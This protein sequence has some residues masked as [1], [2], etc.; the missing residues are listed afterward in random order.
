MHFDTHLHFDYETKSR[1]NLKVHGLARYAAHPSTQIQMVSYAFNDDPVKQWTEDDIDDFP[2]ELIEAIRDP[3]VLKHAHNAAFERA[4][5]AGVLGIETDPRSWRCTMAWA[6][7]LGL[8]GALER[9]GPVLRLPPEMLKFASGKK[10]MR[11]FMA[12]RKPTKKMPYEWRSAQT[13]PE[14]WRGYC[15]YNVQDTETER[16]IAN[17]RL[18][19]FEIVDDEWEVWAID[20]EINERGWP[21]D[22]LMVE[23]ARSMV[24]EETASLRQRLGE[25]TGLQNPNSD[26]QFRPW[27]LQ[28]GYSYGDM[29]KETVAKALRE[30]RL[31]DDARE[32]LLLRAQLKRTSVKKY[33]TVYDFLSADD[34]LRNTFQYGGAARTLRWAGRGP[35]YHNLKKPPKHLEDPVLLRDIIEAIRLKDVEWLVDLYD[36]PMTALSAVIRGTVRAPEGKILKVADLSA[37]EACVLAW[38]ARCPS[39]LQVFREGK[40]IYKAFGQHVYLKPYDELTKE[41]RNNSK[42]GALGAGYRLSGGEEKID[43]KT[44]D[45]KKTGLWGYAENM[46]IKLTKEESHKS[47]QVFREI[48]PE[49]PT[50]WYDLERAMKK[51]INSKQ[52]TWV[53]YIRFDISGPFLRARLPSGRCLHYLRPKIELRDMPYGEPK[54]TVTYEG[55]EDNGER[56]FWGRIPTHGGKVTENLC[57]AIARDVLANGIIEARSEGFIIDGHV[58]DELVVETDIDDDYLTVALLEDCMTRKQPWMRGLPL[59]AHGFETPFY[60]KD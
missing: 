58:H 9:L 35:Q 54:W 40:D 8:P 48:Y 39:M 27:V 38:V 28:R 44:G 49:V 23:N 13:H 20:Q 25:L 16:F 19:R 22:R 60:R 30:E 17:H 33:E 52:E 29:R 43:E 32:A 2:R 46:G 31:F 21:I 5:T 3:H 12:P 37:I 4:L 6:Y 51:T 59:S 15:G 14:E 10:L 7:M 50:F 47:V 56:K 26:P 36:D 1:V 34:R 45:L 55:M 53:G 24:L 18:S 42:P 41:E 11:L 57:Q